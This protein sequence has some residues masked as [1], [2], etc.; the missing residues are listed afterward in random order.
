MVCQ[1]SRDRKSST[2]TNT[3]SNSKLPLKKRSLIAI[4]TPIE[5]APL[6]KEHLDAMSS[7]ERQTH[8]PPVAT[9]SVSDD[10]RSVASNSTSSQQATPQ[11][12][13]PGIAF[14]QA[15]VVIALKERDQMERIKVAQAM[16][17]EAYLQALRGE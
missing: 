5:V 3:T 11:L 4:T 13:Q 17:R 1:R 10:S 6:T 2:P 15:V 16:L 7:P 12:P 8:P 9:I 14:G